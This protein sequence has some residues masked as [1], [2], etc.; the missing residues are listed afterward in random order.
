MPDGRG[1]AVKQMRILGIG[2]VG[3]HLE[4]SAL[5]PAK[6]LQ[7]EKLLREGGCANRLVERRGSICRWGVPVTAGWKGQNAIYC[8]LVIPALSFVD[9][10]V[11]TTLTKVAR[12]KDEGIQKLSTDGK[13]RPRHPKHNDAQASPTPLKFTGSLPTLPNWYSRRNAAA[14]GKENEAPREDGVYDTKE[15]AI[16]EIDGDRKRFVKEVLSE[17]IFL[18]DERGDEGAE[19][20]TY[21]PTFHNAPAK[22]IQICGKIVNWLRIRHELLPA[23]HSITPIY[24]S[25]IKID[26]KLPLTNAAPAKGLQRYVSRWNDH[27]PQIS[28]IV[29]AQWVLM[30]FV[31]A[32]MHSITSAYSGNIAVA[33]KL[34]WTNAAPAKGL[35]RYVLP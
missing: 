18:F 8:C 26:L 10:K 22:F 31:D 17:N 20:E 5:I 3:G 15:L 12:S 32:A 30:Q 2:A 28:Y 4:L 34:P 11:Y 35:Q 24:L 9:R 21:F 25:N 29:K 1:G 23:T 27:P 19:S 6:A 7:C 16:N 13:N 33:L 14:E